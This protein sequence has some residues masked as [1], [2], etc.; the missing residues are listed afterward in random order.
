MLHMP[1]D[2]A[3]FLR[4]LEA[5]TRVTQCRPSCATQHCTP[6]PV[7][8][9]CRSRGGQGKG[10]EK[11]RAGG[12]ARDEEGGGEEEGKTGGEWE[13]KGMRPRSIWH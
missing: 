2:I 1:I 4:T 6:V 10:R 5:V 13:G 3:R 11:G 12:R 7:L 9:L 8:P